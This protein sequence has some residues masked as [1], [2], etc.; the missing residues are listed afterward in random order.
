MGSERVTQ[1][2]RLHQKFMQNPGLTVPANQLCNRANVLPARIRE[3][4]S[5]RDL[6]KRYLIFHSH[7]ATKLQ[8]THLRIHGR[9]IIPAK[10]NHLSSNTHKKLQIEHLQKIQEICLNLNVKSNECANAIQPKYFI[11]H[12]TFSKKT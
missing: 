5:S 1:L 10:T 6:V 4:K 8:R 9:L 7:V 3:S 12:E 2:L 11:F